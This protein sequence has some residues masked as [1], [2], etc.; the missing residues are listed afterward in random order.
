M[1]KHIIKFLVALMLINFSI[2]QTSAKT[3]NETGNIFIQEIEVQTNDVAPVFVVD[4][5]DVT[6]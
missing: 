4:P 3:C 2:I 1:R 5:D 6:L